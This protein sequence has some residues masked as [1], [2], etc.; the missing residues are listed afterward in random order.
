MILIRVSGKI[1]LSSAQKEQKVMV[2]TMQMELM[3][4]IKEGQS[5]RE[6]ARD[7]VEVMLILE[8]TIGTKTGMV[9]I[10][11]HTKIKESKIPNGS[12][13]AKTDKKVH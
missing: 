3:L 13:Q 9:A 6:R 12:L 1:N 11:A 2:E 10:K 5:L 7:W 8:P 4:L